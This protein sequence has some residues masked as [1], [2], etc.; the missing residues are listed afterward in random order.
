MPLVSCQAF[1]VG[2]SNYMA[3]S[4]YRKFVLRISCN[5]LI[6]IAHSLNYVECTTELG[7]IVKSFHTAFISDS[8]STEIHTFHLSQSDLAVKIVS[9]FGYR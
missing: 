7:I 3:P 5:Y 2:T 9:I 6:V 8:P 1:S 4:T